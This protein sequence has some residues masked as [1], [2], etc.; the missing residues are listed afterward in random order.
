M[1]KEMNSILVI[2][3][4]QDFTAI[5]PTLSHQKCFHYLAPKNSNA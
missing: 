4:C 2:T 3:N 5:I 1:G